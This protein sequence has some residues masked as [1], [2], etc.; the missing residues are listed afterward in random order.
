M[1]VVSHFE[2]AISPDEAQFFLNH[3]F[4]P[5]KLPDQSDHDHAAKKLL[6]LFATIAHKY[7]DSL[8]QAERLEWL[9]IANSISTWRD[10]YSP[11]TL[12]EKVIEE[13][14]KSM[15]YQGM[16]SNIYCQ[17]R[18]ILTSSS[19]ITCLPRSP[20]HSCLSNTTRGCLQV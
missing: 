13:R 5:P 16:E 19:Y 14:L 8:D 15:D 20:E 4:L 18:L 17:N 1:T 2:M 10:V 6:T 9:P 11:G 3:L 7:G 12:C